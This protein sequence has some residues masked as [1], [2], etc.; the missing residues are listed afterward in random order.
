[1]SDVEDAAVLLINSESVRTCGGHHENTIE[2]QG[3]PTTL[4]GQLNS[5]SSPPAAGISILLIT[6]ACMAALGGLLFGYD[7]GII[8]T[9]LPQVKV[10]F[11][12]SCLQEEMTVSF[13]LFGALF[14]S[15]VGGKTFTFYLSVVKS[16]LFIY[17]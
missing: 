3:E 13:M 1:M 2:T 15:L 4:N 16:H 7:V 10:A 14:A 17:F 11:S 12:L 9:A 6:S 8:S 5:L